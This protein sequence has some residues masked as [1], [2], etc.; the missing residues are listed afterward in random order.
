MIVDLYI[1]QIIND[2]AKQKDSDEIVE[3]VFHANADYS[4]KKEEFSDGVCSDEETKIKEQNAIVLDSEDDDVP[5]VNNNQ[6]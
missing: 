5:P 2:V 1:S 4:L 6:Q 3:I